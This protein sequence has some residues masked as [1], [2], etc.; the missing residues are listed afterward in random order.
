MTGVQTC[1]LPIYNRGFFIGVIDVIFDHSKV[2]ISLVAF[3]AI[4][5]FA[6]GH[7]PINLVEWMDILIPSTVYTILY[8]YTKRVTAS[9]VTH[10]LWNTLAVILIFIIYS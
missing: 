1:A 7:L 5:F 10:S 8:L 9:I 4:I 2:A 3:F 6:A